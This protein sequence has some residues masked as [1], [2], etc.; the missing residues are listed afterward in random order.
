M[1]SVYVLTLYV[2]GQSAGSQR[3]VANLRSLATPTVIA[4]P[5]VAAGEGHA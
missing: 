3:A 5:V 2:T 1:T 4:R